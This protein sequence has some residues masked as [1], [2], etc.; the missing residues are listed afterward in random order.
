MPPPRKSKANSQQNVDSSSILCL[1]K[2]TK[3][4]KS[5]LA[6]ENLKSLIW[7]PKKCLPMAVI[8]IV[9]E[10][11]INFFVI[12]TRKYTEIDWIAYMQEVEGMFL[13]WFL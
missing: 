7:D 1:T 12:S 5:F 10:L 3:S 2:I 8:L 6:I 11:F 13:Y 9:A 4:V